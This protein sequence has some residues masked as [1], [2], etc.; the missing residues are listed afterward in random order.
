VL[1]LLA[2]TLAGVALADRARKQT[3]MNDAWVVAWEC[4]ETGGAC[5]DP[6]PAEIERRWQ[7]REE[8]YTAAGSALLVAAPIGLLFFGT[9][10]TGATA[11]RRVIGGARRTA[12]IARG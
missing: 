3:Q 11:R 1:A 12:S 4:P 2:V 7:A 8:W 10:R 6:H 5:S 9:R